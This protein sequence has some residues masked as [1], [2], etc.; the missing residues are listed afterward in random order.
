MLVWF[1]INASLRVAL[2]LD[3]S[4]RHTRRL[5]PASTLGTLR[6][7][8]CLSRGCGGRTS[9]GPYPQWSRCPLRVAQVVIEVQL[10][11]SIADN[12]LPAVSLPHRQL[13]G[14]R[15]DPSPS[16]MESGRT[17]QV[18]LSFDCDQLELEH[19]PVAVVLLP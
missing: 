5:A 15:D 6:R 2:R 9:V 7:S 3:T 17:T 16:R 1:A 11:G 19:L 18:L 12:A 10:L 4:L 8:C 13:H 14:R